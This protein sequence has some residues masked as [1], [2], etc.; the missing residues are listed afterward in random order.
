MI[1]KVQAI[2]KGQRW[3]FCYD[4]TQFALNFKLLQSSGDF[5]P[6]YVKNA[7]EIKNQLKLI[8]S[9]LANFHQYYRNQYKSMD[10][11]NRRILRG[12]KKISIKNILNINQKMM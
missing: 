12:K 2:T 4:S 7:P 5:V 6:F 3:Q 9:N 11:Y 1:R 8:N 10:Y